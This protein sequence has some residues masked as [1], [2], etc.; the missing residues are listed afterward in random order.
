MSYPPKC[1]D[2][3]SMLIRKEVKEHPGKTIEECPKC[4]KK[5]RDKFMEMFYAKH[6]DMKP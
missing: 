2:C 1:P 5:R 3:G 6:P 4:E